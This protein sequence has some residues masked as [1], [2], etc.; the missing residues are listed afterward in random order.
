MEASQATHW[1]E[2]GP[3]PPNAGGVRDT[4]LIPGWERYPGVGNGNMLQYSCQKKSWTE[5]PDGLQSIGLQSPT[6]LSDWTYTR[7]KRFQSVQSLHH[8]RLCDPMDCSTPGFPVH[9]QLP[10][11][12]QTHVHRVG[13]TIQPSHPLLS[14]PASNL[15]PASGS[16]PVRQFFTS[17]GQSIGASAS[18]SVLPMNIQDQFPFQ[19]LEKP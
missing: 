6:Q 19:S 5:E 7:I 16:F 11:L 1:E 8:V 15:K 9:H 10:D 12:A 13:D 2:E 17:G 4:G 14:P 3:P 18:A